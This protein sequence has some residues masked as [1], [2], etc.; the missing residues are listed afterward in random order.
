M[1]GMLTLLLEYNYEVKAGKE[2][3]YKLIIQISTGEIRFEEIV[4]WLK[5]NTLELTSIQT[6]LRDA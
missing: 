4:L 6:A 3:L 1:L 5:E 2:D